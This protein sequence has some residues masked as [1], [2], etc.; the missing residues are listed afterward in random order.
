MLSFIGFMLELGN[1]Y[2]GWVKSHIIV[3]RKALEVAHSSLPLHVT[4]LDN[5]SDVFI[6]ARDF[7]EMCTYSW[8]I[9]HNQGYLDGCQGLIND[10]D[11]VIV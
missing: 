3:E 9:S 10:E 1:H 7:P 8:L 6:W 2:L 11:L 4:A 5:T